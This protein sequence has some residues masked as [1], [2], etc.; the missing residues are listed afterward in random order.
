MNPDYFLNHR[1]QFLVASHADGFIP[2][3]MTLSEL[4]DEF[5]PLPCL[6]CVITNNS[7]R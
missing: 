7:N 4:E 1:D 3:P 2:W 6:D 5:P